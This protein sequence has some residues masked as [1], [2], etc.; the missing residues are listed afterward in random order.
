MDKWSV[1]IYLSPLPFQGSMPCIKC[2]IALKNYEEFFQH[3]KQ[4]HFRNVCQECYF[5][6]RNRLIVKRHQRNC[7]PVVDFDENAQW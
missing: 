7:F 3:M 1:P 2:K 6:H 4:F 5:Y